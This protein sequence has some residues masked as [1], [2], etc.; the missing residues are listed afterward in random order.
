MTIYTVSSPVAPLLAEPLASSEQVSQA[1]AGHQ[2]TQLEVRGG[3][4][5]VRLRDGY[6]G[7]M[8]EGY[9]A[10]APRD[11]H[12]AQTAFECTRCSLG[13][14]VQDASGRARA[15]PVGAR[16][17]AS[18]KVVSGDALTAAELRV[19]FPA[20]GSAIAAS[21]LLLFTGT[22]YQWGGVTPWGADCSGM[23]QTAFGLHGMSLPRDA[24]QQADLGIVVQT[25][26]ALSQPGDLLFFSDRDD[27]C[28]THVALSL[29]E[30][31][32]AHLAIGRGGFSIERMSDEADLYTGALMRRLRGIRRLL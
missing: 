7:W 31:R 12:E 8:H 28:I 24:R 20:T 23:V 4:R 6:E 10:A 13:C 29:G 19:R 32:L 15:L 30:G 25:E 3:W 22:S 21:T 5:R 9:L 14:T 1:L 18:A 2:C 11:P 17:G 27:G 26:P 16:V